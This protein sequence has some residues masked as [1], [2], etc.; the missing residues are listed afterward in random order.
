MDSEIDFDAVTK[1]FGDTKVFDDASFRLEPG[2]T[3][4]VGR[5]GAGKS[6]LVRLA[7]GL[8]RPNAGHVSIFGEPT[9]SISLRTKRRFGVQLQ[10]DAFVKGVRVREY[11]DLYEKMYALERNSPAPAWAL[12]TQRA[13]EMLGIAPLMRSYAYTMSGGQK[14]RVSLLLAIIGNKELIV[15]DEPTAGIDADVKESILRVIRLLREAGVNLLV[16]SHDLRE[17][18]DIADNVVVV[19]RGLRFSGSKLAFMERYG[20]THK[21]SVPYPLADVQLQRLE[22]DD[23]IAYFGRSVAE[24]STYFSNELIVPTT[25]VDLYQIA[26]LRAESENL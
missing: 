2:L 7:T 18:F 22:H 16:S 10:N 3:F 11:V 21:V 8:E 14:K 19:E 6:T 1:S 12:D 20:Y 15:L 24:L 5:N 17:F 13:V 25:T 4:L 23:G 9:H 26:T